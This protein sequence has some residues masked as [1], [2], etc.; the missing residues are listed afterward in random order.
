MRWFL[1]PA[2]VVPPSNFV[3]NA[4]PP[5]YYMVNGQAM[6]QYQVM[7]INIEYFTK[8]FLTFFTPW[9]PVNDI[10]FGTLCLLNL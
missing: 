9:T 2:S 7:Y 6:G 8:C 10:V 4:P 1:A 3:P 5:F